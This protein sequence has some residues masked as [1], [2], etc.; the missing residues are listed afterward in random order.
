MIFDLLRRRRDTAPVSAT[1]RLAAV[2][3]RIAERR[4]RLA[5][6]EPIHPD[7]PDAL[8]NAADGSCLNCGGAGRFSAFGPDGRT[9]IPCPCTRGRNEYGEPVA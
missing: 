1:E 7:T 2:D 3:P 9:W 8:F 5:Y 6:V 4:A